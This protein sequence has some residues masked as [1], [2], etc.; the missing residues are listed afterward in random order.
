M[1][2]I[3]WLLLI[4][5]IGGCLTTVVYA[6]WILISP[7]LKMVYKD[8]EENAEHY[9][10]EMDSMERDYMLCISEDLPTRWFSGI[11]NRFPIMALTIMWPVNALY[12]TKYLK[13]IVNNVANTYKK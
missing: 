2:T 12:H 9:I 7:A 4:W 3:G 13:P 6:G 10:E 5:S 11:I 1:R 8:Q